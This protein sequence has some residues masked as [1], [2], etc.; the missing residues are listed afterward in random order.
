MKRSRILVYANGWGHEYLNRSVS[1]MYEAA[2]AMNAD[3]FVFVNF[4]KFSDSDETN[5]GEMD[6][7]RLPNPKDFDGMIVMANS[8]NMEKEIVFVL[9]ELHLRHLTLI[10]LN[11]VL[12]QM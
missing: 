8:F 4:S 6:I 10:E 3:L 9:R 1:G 5:A 2:K 7:F 11:S 12:I